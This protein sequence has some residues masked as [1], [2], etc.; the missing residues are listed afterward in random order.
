MRIKSQSV[1]EYGSTPTPHH[2]FGDGWEHEIKID[3][4]IKPG[5]GLTTPVCLAGEF[6]CPPED[7]G[8]PWAYNDMTA[9]LAD[10]SSEERARFLDW[11]GA[12]F[13]PHAFSLDDVNKRLA[14]L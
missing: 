14:R 10:P 7:C 8:G 4:L 1:R 2:D 11:L 5:S 13:D 6:A 12:D 9:T 3:K